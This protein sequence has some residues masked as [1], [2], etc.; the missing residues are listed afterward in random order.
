V[1]DIMAFWG[2]PDESPMKREVMVKLDEAAY[3]G[4]FEVKAFTAM[5]NP[6]SSS[7][8]TR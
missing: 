8:R 3:T 2:I 5:G 1:F 6:Q 4:G 7:T